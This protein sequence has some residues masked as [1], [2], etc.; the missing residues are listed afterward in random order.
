MR[1]RFALCLFAVAALNFS[2]AATFTIAPAAVSNT[3]S[4]TVTLQV[5]GLTN[6]ESVLIQKYLDANT[7]G[8]VDA[9]DRLWQQFN[10]TDGQASV[11]HDGATAVT[12]LNV[13]GDLDSTAG[14]ITA[15]LNL[16]MSGFEQAIVGKYLYVLSSPYG[17]FSP[18][19]N[20]FVVTN[21]PFPQSVSGSAVANSTNVPNAVVLFFQQSSGGNMNPQ[22][23]TV[24]DNSGNYTFSI[25]PGTYLTAAFQDGFVANLGISPVVNVNS[26]ASLSTNV[27][28]GSA[29]RTISGRIFDASNSVVGLAGML[30]PITSKNGLLTVAFTDANGNF[31]AGVTADQ[32]KVE[33]S[34]AAPAFHGYLRSQN[35]TQVD[36]TAGS[37][38][39][40]NIA[41]P[42]ANA[43]F[44]GHVKDG[45]NVPMPGISLFSNDSSNYEQSVTTDANGNYFAGALS[46]PN[47]VWQVQIS[48]DTN[49]TNYNYSSP[50]WMLNNQNGGT[51]LSVGQAV[52]ANFAALI[53][54]NQIIGH[55]QDSSGN[56]ITNVQVFAGADIGGV[57]Y[58]AQ[59]NTDASGNYSLNVANG[60]WNV[61]VSC[62]GG[63][64]SLDS[65]LGNG[66]YLCPN[67][68]TVNITN[69]N[70]AAN[71]T[72]QPC[73]SVQIYTSSPLPNG[74]VGN[75]YSVQ[76][77]A[78]SCNG[79]FNWSVNSGTVP[80]G[81]TL[82]S[83]GA[84]NGTPTTNGTFNFT[85]HVSDGS[86]A[87]TNQN[88]S[89]TI[90][91]PPTPPTIS[92]P[93]HFL[94]GQFQMTVSGS[95]GQTYTVQGTTYLASTNWIS[96]LI[97]NPS[98]GSFLFRDPNATNAS[99]FYRVLLG[100]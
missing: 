81:L 42:K 45:A 9:G 23:G 84:F 38:S 16:P 67:S 7:N 13:P 66:N 40:V 82:Y 72:V 22:G 79:N 100:P 8:V 57:P 88:F 65:I 29:D 96:L 48:N 97:T 73:G 61:S 30:T 21:F 58:S 55:V 26:G 91:P 1:S 36:A 5:T 47:D 33:D 46:A 44:Y 3:Y 93:A 63:N 15:V 74:Q 90:N 52:L 92:A 2:R 51:N 85:V 35:K 54:T 70:G 24:A 69:S 53:A 76:F 11:F 99:R 59:M 17:N 20:S 14:Q 89:V 86:G 94:S 6:G 43:L 78:S 31:I 95:A 28:L 71:F 4:G 68:Q 75:Y 56:P 34:D 18:V 10:L 77:N 64:N 12:N 25:T 87:S 19:T 98:S 49:P 41:V 80:P 83:G 60:S 39:G 37:V 62:Q 27:P 50:T 32:W